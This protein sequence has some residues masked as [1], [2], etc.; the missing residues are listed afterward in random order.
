MATKTTKGSGGDDNPQAA[1]TDDDFDS[2][3]EDDLLELVE[4]LA[5]RRA[6]RRPAPAGSTG[7]E[8]DAGADAD[9][10]RDADTADE[11]A[12]EPPAKG[13]ADVDA[14]PA[15]RTGAKTDAK[16]ETETEIETEAEAGAEAKPKGR[17][18]AKAGPEART[19]PKGRPGAGTEPDAE[20][21]DS[22]DPEAGDAEDGGKRAGPVAGDRAAR[23]IRVLA[24]LSVV[25]A[26][27]LA[28]VSTFAFV[29]WREYGSG[30]SPQAVRQKVAERAGVIVSTL[31]TY[32]YHDAKGYL[33]KQAAVMTK[34]AAAAVKPNWA[35]L[36]TL[37]ETGKYVSTAQIEQV[38]VGDVSGDKASVIV[39]VNNKLVTSRGIQNSVGATLQFSLAK[40]NG[41]WLASAV[42]K[43]ESTGVQTN[44][45]LQGK[46]LQAATPTPSPGK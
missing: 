43:L 14:D 23:R 32:D 30:S 18:G 46:P 29:Q 39:V 38:Y 13:E 41:V 24:V 40:E 5:R 7:A 44:T 17:A 28:A 10:G 2:A 31:F 6:R 26:T 19:R 16:T 20:A 4:R 42:P 36:T 15:Q 3:Y 8:T 1:V 37:F 21:E 35:T 27:A 25:L 22:A 33:E 34:S 9:T 45:D 12:D 11:T